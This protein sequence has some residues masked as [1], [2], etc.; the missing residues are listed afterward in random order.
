MT[1]QGPRLCA[2]P[3]VQNHYKLMTHPPNP[4]VCLGTNACVPGHAQRCRTLESVKLRRSFSFGERALLLHGLRIKPSVALVLHAE[5]LH[6]LSSTFFGCRFAVI[7]FVLPIQAVRRVRS[8]TVTV[9]IRFTARIRSTISA[10]VQIRIGFRIGIKSAVHSM[11]LM[12]ITCILQLGKVQARNRS[13][14]RLPSQ[15]CQ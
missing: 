9:T 2:A 4:T 13:S 12:K 7:L 14:S 6:L 1:A 10:R 8:L 3:L 15:H 5:Q 11:I